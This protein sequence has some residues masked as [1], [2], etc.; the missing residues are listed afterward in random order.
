MYSQY[1]T[2][3]KSQWI[4]DAL[5]RSLTVVETLLSG[6]LGSSGDCHLEPL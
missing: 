4:A 1:F 2:G 3:E 5:I 6:L